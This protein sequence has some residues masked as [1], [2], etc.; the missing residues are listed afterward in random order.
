MTK[1]NRRRNIGVELLRSRE[2]LLAAR[3]LADQGLGNDAVSRAYYGA[4]H[5]A[6]ALLLTLGLEARTHAG[7]A[8]L[9]KLHFEARVGEEQVS[10]FARLQTFR[11]AA[12]YD[13]ETRF[14][15]EEASEEVS[16]AEELAELATQL[17][18]EDGW[19]ESI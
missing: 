11:H 14:E 17:L 19:L 15:A 10:A 3:T 13:A 18:A 6:R 4:Y 16:K 9:L 12:D 5:V 2:C 8:R 1:D 7:L